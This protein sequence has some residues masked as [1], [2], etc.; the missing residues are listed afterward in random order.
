M[1][2]ARNLLE[3]IQG[4][5]DTLSKAERKVAEVILRNPQQATRLSIAALAQTAEVS[6]P[7]VNRF[8]RSFGVNGY[9]ELKM[10]LAQS[11]ASGAAYVSRA[12][13][14]SDGPDAYTRK[15]F[16][17]AIASLDSACQSLDPQLISRAVDMMIQARQIHFFG[18][19]ASAPVALDAQHKFFRFNLAVSA[20]ADVLMQ[21]MLASVAHTGELFVI[22]S[23]TGRTREL[24]EVARIARQNGASVLALTAAGS[25]LAKASSLSVD[26]PLPEDTD[27]YMPMTS[28][29]IQLTVLDVLATGVTLRRGVDFQPHLRKI[30]ESLND[31][32]Y[33]VDSDID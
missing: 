5:L 27:I 11:L 33:P 7:T 32:R 23:Y 10:Q 4:R 16:G 18:L 15:I 31:S 25:P 1:D 20:H 17:S 29:I 28:R 2:R 13:E 19:G 8:C 9:P 22:I 30:K 6:E 3:Q 24:V 21:R 14:A 26:I 12:V